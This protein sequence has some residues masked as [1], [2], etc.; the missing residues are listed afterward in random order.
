VLDDLLAEHGATDDI[1]HEEL[2]ATTV[3]P[4]AGGHGDDDLARQVHPA[5]E[6]RAARRVERRPLQGQPCL[7]NRKKRSRQ[8]N[9]D[10]LGDRRDRQCRP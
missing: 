2:F 7:T 4:V 6:P 10:D 1:D 3:L 5:P 9:H 8:E